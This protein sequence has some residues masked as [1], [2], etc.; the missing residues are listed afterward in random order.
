MNMSPLTSLFS[1]TTSLL[2]SSGMN[3][4]MVSVAGS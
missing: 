1:P 2:I 3:S 4:L